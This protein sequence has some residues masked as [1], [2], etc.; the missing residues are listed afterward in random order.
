MEKKTYLFRWIDYLDR[1]RYTE[2]RTFSEDEIEPYLKAKRVWSEL[3]EYEE[4]LI[5]TQEME[6]E[7][8][9]N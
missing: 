8:N 6:N 5:I 1:S 7:L 9:K 4:D 2:R 3:E